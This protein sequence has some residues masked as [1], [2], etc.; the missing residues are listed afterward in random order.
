MV[1][2]LAEV[3]ISPIASE[4]PKRDQL[5]GCYAMGV[6]ALAGKKD[7][8]STRVAKTLLSRTFLSSDPLLAFALEFVTQYK[9]SFDELADSQWDRDK[10][11]QNKL[12]HAFASEAIAHTANQIDTVSTSSQVD[13]ELI[14][15]TISI[16]HLHDDVD[17]PRYSTV[18]VEGATRDIWGSF[19]S[20]S[21]LVREL[22]RL[23]HETEKVAPV[24]LKH[25]GVFSEA[26]DTPEGLIIGKKYFVKTVQDDALQFLKKNEPAEIERIQ[27]LLSMADASP[28]LFAH[29]T[30]SMMTA[31]S[32]A[33]DYKTI[34][35]EDSTLGGLAGELLEVWKK[36]PEKYKGEM[37]GIK[38]VLQYISYVQPDRAENEEVKLMMK[39][40]QTAILEAIS[41]NN[42][43]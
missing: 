17:D 41:L 32:N 28:R 12:V 4:A 24:L 37:A 20:E 9:F 27:I 2:L 3:A 30:S 39:Q 35:L 11:D 7:D 43:E 15:N 29:L 19:G 26:L 40:L 5:F 38:N 31:L 23:T 22:F 36:F 18:L 13:P 42:K 14:H 25:K 8:F 1:K 6:L 10:Q 33:A 16:G 21:A 34:A